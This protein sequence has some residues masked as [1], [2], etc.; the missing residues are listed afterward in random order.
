MGN[1]GGIAHTAQ[2]VADVS[3]RARQLWLHRVT[4]VVLWSETCVKLFIPTAGRM[5]LG[6]D[7]K[8]ETCAYAPQ[9]YLLNQAIALLQGRERSFIHIIET[10][11]SI[12]VELRATIEALDAADRVGLATP[13]VLASP[14]ETPAPGKQSHL[15]ASAIKSR[16]RFAKLA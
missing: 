13:F 15:M 9:E 12:P 1:A 11:D 4:W 7:S 5:T 16:S 8:A 10:A 3:R 14:A 6:T 2:D